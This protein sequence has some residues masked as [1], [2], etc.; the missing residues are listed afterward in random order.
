MERRQYSDNDKATALAALDA[1]GGNVK[2]TA[3]QLQIPRKTLSQWQDGRV[4]NDVAQL[5]HQKGVEL[6]DLIRAELEAIMIAL[7]TKRKDATYAQLATAAGIFTDKMRLL[8]DKSTQNVD[9]NVTDAKL[10]LEHLITRQIAESTAGSDI[11]PT[12]G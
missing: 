2:L 1:N 7:P 11:S 3:E 12:D 10:K 8:E 9:L 4:N 5:R 6:K